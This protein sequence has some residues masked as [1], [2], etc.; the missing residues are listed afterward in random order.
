MLAPA[1]PAGG[2]LGTVARPTAVSDAATTS[3][4]AD[5][6][7]AGVGSGR[8]EVAATRA[9][10]PAGNASSTAAQLTTLRTRPPTLGT[11]R[12]GGEGGNGA[13]METS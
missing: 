3:D 13:S 1:P 2:M 7:V 12:T 6:A 8:N 9:A 11:V 4:A 5:E 10:P